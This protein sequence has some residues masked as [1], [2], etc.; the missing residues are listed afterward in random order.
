M[1][2][3][4]VFVLLGT[5]LVGLTALRITPWFPTD[6]AYISFRYAQHWAA[7]NGPVF[8][9]GERVEG[10]SNFLY[11]ALLAGGAGVGI[12][13]PL[14]SRLLNLLSV[15]AVVG[16][17]LWGLPSSAASR[18]LRALGG[19]V[20]V[21]SSITIVNVLSGLEAPFMAALVA[22]GIV[23]LLRGWRW[24]TPATFLLVAL[25]RPEG[26][27][28]A[29][30]GATIAT[31]YAMRAGSW[32]AVRATAAYWLTASA[33]PYG[34]FLAWRLYFY[35][36]LLP[37]SVIA[38]QGR[39]WLE[40]VERALPYVMSGAKAFAPFLVLAAL[41]LFAC[42]WRGK[43]QRVAGYG[44]V[45][46][47]GIFG[48]GAVIGSG[49]PYAP[50]VRYL[51][52]AVPPLIM[53]AIVGAEALLPAS[54]GTGASPWHSL[55]SAAVAALLA[56]QVVLA[57]R[58]VPG[59]YHFDTPAWKRLPSGLVSV[60]SQDRRPHTAEAQNLS[61]G[62]H[63]LAEY[64]RKNASRHELL[65]TAE[66][67]ITPYYTGMPTL[68]TVGL[69]DRHIAR[70]PGIPGVKADADYVFARSPEY[71][72]FKKRTD[73]LCG[74]VPA[75]VAYLR[76]PRM[77]ERYRLAHVV[78]DG[79]R[80]IL[81]LRR[82]QTSA[83][84]TFRFVDRFDYDRVRFV[85]GGET[86]QHPNLAKMVTGAS[87][88][89][90]VGPAGRT[91]L[92]M[93]LLAPAATAAEL[94]EAWA[95]WERSWMPL[96]LTLPPPGGLATEVAY[97]ISIPKDAV[98]KFAI[99]LA[100]DPRDHSTASGVEFEVLLGT[101][102]EP[103]SIYRRVLEPGATDDEGGLLPSAW[104]AE[105]IDLSPYRGEEVEIVFS[106]RHVRRESEQ[107]LFRVGW[108]DPRIVSLAVDSPRPSS[109]DV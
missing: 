32:P 36:D 53:A 98:L 26:A 92:S 58:L 45:F 71:F 108:G 74:G 12:T 83:G 80:S 2:N 78:H 44:L 51:F 55:R 77:R 81:V 73:C 94:S 4:A 59:T 5:L 67:G 23:G 16:V 18:W 97:R 56:S 89:D 63:H 3:L 17:L 93:L 109:G 34:L 75:D 8:N 70:L 86:L 42:A 66:V 88:M 49:D 30:L 82:K 47:A 11:V 90:A 28:L 38:K 21:T 31:W 13:P 95:E 25:T 39:G 14:G 103:T 24:L 40:N 99:G 10:Y 35:G 76:D 64:L 48:I 1:R 29:V 69:V 87:A 6:D 7:G 9:V 33:L 60:F 106:V 20:M 15:L 101:G 43:G 22:L 27:A 85:D 102:G 41:G 61:M 84:E 54:R 65:A 62:L 96:L 50:F 37:N 104:Q 57:W 68:D 46:V 107:S 79:A 91:R 105:S 52:P 19:L 100:T 72:A